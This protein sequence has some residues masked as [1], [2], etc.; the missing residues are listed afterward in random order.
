MSEGGGRRLPARY[1]LPVTG[2]ILSGIMTIIISGISTLLALGHR[3][4]L[5]YE[6]QRTATW[7][8]NEF[9][10]DRLPVK[11]RGRRLGIVGLAGWMADPH[12]KPPGGLLVLLAGT[13][14]IAVLAAPRTVPAA[15]RA[16]M[17]ELQ[18]GGSGTWW[19]AALGRLR[20]SL[21]SVA[22][23][24]PATLARIVVLSMAAQIPGALVFVVLGR[25]LGLDVSLP[26]MAWVRSVVVLFTVL[27][28]SI[29]G[30][31]VREGVLVLVLG[32]YGV[33]SSDA[34]A[35]SILVFAATILAPGLVG[36]ALEAV[37]WLRG[38]VGSPRRHR[39]VRRP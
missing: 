21:G 34:L 10:G 22:R 33:A 27:P 5:V 13:S 9:V 31:G 25:G 14:A 23:L 1:T 26:A 16:F 3:L 29:G 38:D 30:L 4:P 39:V 37:H 20:L 28:I 24:S 8:Q 35:L 17:R 19:S 32:S 12:P 7:A 36:G 18:A 6:R 15:W 2:F 11:L